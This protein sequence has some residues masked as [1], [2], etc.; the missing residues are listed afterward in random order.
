M[1]HFKSKIRFVETFAIATFP[2]AL[3]VGCTTTSDKTASLGIEEA[4]AIQ[5]EADIND[6]DLNTLTYLETESTS[7]QMQA[8]EQE[9]MQKSQSMETESDSIQTAEVMP[10]EETSM[11]NT[12]VESEF[13]A[14]ETDTMPVNLQM[15][16]PAKPAKP[17]TG[18]FHFAYNQ[19]DVAEQDRELLKDHAEYLLHNP[20]IVV[21]V[22]GHTDNRGTSK[23]NVLVSQKRA[24]HVADVL[25]SY[26]VPK[27]QI[28][29]NGYG[30]SF[31]LNDEKN[32]DENRRVE[33]QYGE[34]PESD[35]LIVSA[36]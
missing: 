12:S 3:A 2:I 24:Q 22:N 19:Y 31:P 33:L 9:A 6:S 32:W 21:N 23:N 18:I 15:P 35:G 36:F 25:M 17:Q 14:E 13:T 30:E 4:V 20:D 29:V 8:G 11:E 34:D 5:Q 16:E 27:S 10:T 26:G 28:N 1:K 7:T